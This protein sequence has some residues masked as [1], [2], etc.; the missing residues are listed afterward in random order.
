MNVREDEAAVI[1]C[2][3]MEDGRKRIQAQDG[4]DE[5]DTSAKTYSKEGGKRVI[6]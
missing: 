6:G 5:K 4:F 3:R 2:M 1:T